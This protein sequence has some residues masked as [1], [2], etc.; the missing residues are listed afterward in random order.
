M[1]NLTDSGYS[2]SRPATAAWWAGES[3]F[4]YEGDETNSIELKLQHE[5]R[6]VIKSEQADRH[7]QSEAND[8]HLHRD[9]PVI[10]QR[11]SY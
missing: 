7:G 6:T 8:S 9:S 11:E 3:W 5:S 1:R 10:Y 4:D 2:A